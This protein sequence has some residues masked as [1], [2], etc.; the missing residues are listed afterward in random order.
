MLLYSYYIHNMC[1]NG[2]NM[3]Y[4]LVVVHILVSQ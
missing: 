4:V 3:S 2:T 1:E